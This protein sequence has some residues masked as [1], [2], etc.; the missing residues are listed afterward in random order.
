MKEKKHTKVRKKRGG[1]NN[2]RLA[3]V[4]VSSFIVIYFAFEVFSVFISTQET[5][6]AVKVSVND[7]FNAVGWFFRDEIVV[8][9][10]Q[11][12]AVKH[13]VYSGERVQ[14]SAT[15]AAVYSDEQSLAISRQ[16]EPIQNQIKMLN[17]VLQSSNDEADSAKM[18]QLITLSL[19][20]MTEQVRSGSGSSL[21]STVD[22]LRMMSL[23]REV[24]NVDSAAITAERDA[25]V[26]KV[27]DLDA[28][29]SGST[30]ELMA[31]DS[32]YF[33]DIIDGY[34]STLTPAALKNLDMTK[35]HELTSKKT[36]SSNNPAAAMGKIIRGFSWYLVSEIPA[37]EAD[38]LQKGQNL[39]INFVQVAQMAS[40]S[41]Y[42][43]VKERGN[44]TAL[45][46][47]EGTNFSSE[48][49]SMREQPIEIIVARYDGLRVPKQ[50]V[51]MRDNEIGVF[52]LSGSVEKF[53]RINKLYE[54]DDYYVVEQS[55]TD[56]GALVAKDQ[57]IVRGKNL[58]N[59]TVVST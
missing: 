28:Q 37:H 45:I 11:G 57:I 7:S 44:D 18:D 8:E 32:G 41:V 54:T 59:N 27:N 43:I 16:I 33:S 10:Q 58:Q 39:E 17:N 21:S 38:R 47:L 23:R 5:E 40:V 13:V 25:L 49:V 15:L 12:Q 4:L 19:Q 30:R 6:P 53:K 14:K 42:D 56:V 31:S 55:A 35:F 46:V 52:I 26:A 24:S 36:K 1:I 22:S 51:R 9:Q 2:R 29:L 34:E 20:Q 48:I 3:F 50:A